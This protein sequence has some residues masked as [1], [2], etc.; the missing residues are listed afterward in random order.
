[1]TF[2]FYFVN[3]L[4]IMVNKNLSTKYFILQALRKSSTP[5]SGESIAQECGLS[6]TAVW[7]AVQLAVTDVGSGILHSR[8][9]RVA[10][11]LLSDS[12]KL[13]HV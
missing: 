1:M 9:K 12:T 8:H 7:K 4:K 11:E 3:L 10:V 6:R 5:V 13:L 2:A